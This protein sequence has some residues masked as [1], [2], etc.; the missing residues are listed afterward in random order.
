MKVILLQDITHVGKKNEVKEVRDGYAR[1]FLFPQKFAEPATA[2]GVFR[3]NVQQSQGQA[4]RVKEKE[5]YTVLAQQLDTTHL[6]FT[7]KLGQKGRAF[8]SVSIAKII[9]A[10]AREGVHLQ[11]DWV[12]LENPIKMTGEHDILIKF[13]HGV[14]GMLH[15]SIASETS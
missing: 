7:I 12:A 6:H 4:K 8:G 15:I 11:K 1:N 2:Q 13:P 5:Q 14:Q 10:A 3:L 9:E